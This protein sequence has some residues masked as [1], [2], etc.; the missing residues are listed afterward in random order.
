MD[1][2][3]LDIKVEFNYRKRIQSLVINRTVYNKLTARKSSRFVC[4]YLDY[5]I[6]AEIVD[7]EKREKSI[8]ALNLRD[9]N[10][11][12]FMR[13]CLAS[14][15]LREYLIPT[16]QYREFT[17]Q[18]FRLNEPAL[19]SFVSQPYVE[20]VY[21]YDKS[22]LKKLQAKLSDL[23]IRDIKPH[24]VKLDT[25]GNPKVVDYGG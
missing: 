14:N 18:H 1:L 12:E 5:V 21:M 4:R 6:K 9:Q 24:N 17:V 23:N 3:Q 13:W 10:R 8:N 2:N 22:E 20:G 15:A 7:V 25:N 16:L 11:N 19:I